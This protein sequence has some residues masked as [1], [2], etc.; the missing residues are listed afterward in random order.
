MRT[1]NSQMGHAYTLHAMLVDQRHSRN[2]QLKNEQLLTALSSPHPC[3]DYQKQLTT[4][5]T[6]KVFHCPLANVAQLVSRSDD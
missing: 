4:A 6:W 1:H 5:C 3:V 2:W